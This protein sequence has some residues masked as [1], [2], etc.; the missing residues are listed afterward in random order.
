MAAARNCT[1]TGCTRQAVATLTYAYAD[2][3]AVVGPLAG[4]AEPHSYDLCEEHAKKL[5]VPRGWEVMR[6]DV[7]LA[8]GDWSPTVLHETEVV[9]VDDLAALVDVLNETP[10]PDDAPSRESLEQA[11]LSATAGMPPRGRHRA[12]EAQSRRGHLRIVPDSN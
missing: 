1:R 8:V 10:A 4:Y 6:H 7:D 5:T 9:E 12:P 2:L 3:T 11:P